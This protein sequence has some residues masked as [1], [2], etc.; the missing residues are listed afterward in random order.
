MSLLMLDATKISTPVM[1]RTRGRARVHLA[2]TPHGAKLA[3]LH[4]SGSGKAMLPKVHDPVP[5]VV[6]LNTAGGLTGGDRLDYAVTVD[7]GGRAVA[8]SQ[9]AERAYAAVSGEAEVDVH[10]SVGAGGHLDWL[11]QETILFERCSLRRHTRV[12]LQGDA[13]ILMVESVVLGR[14]AMGETLSDIN[15]H[16]T[17]TITRDGVVVLHE[18]VGLSAY[19]LSTGA[20]GLNGSRAFATVILAAPN[21]P[22]RVEQIRALSLPDGVEWGV[23]GWDGKCVM[24]LMAADAT[25]LRRALYQTLTTLRGRQMPRVWQI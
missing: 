13:S 3:G 8:T 18:P 6:F 2:A 4:Q 14:A 20:A 24:R 9:T 15:F 25:P 1:Q 5:E 17:R 22:D 11:P 21:A 23:S 19:D 10:L 7:A 12:D 16:D